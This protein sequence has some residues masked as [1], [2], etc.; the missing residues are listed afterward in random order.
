MKGDPSGIA[1]AKK[2]I[3][4]KETD[5]NILFC[6]YFLSVDYQ[7]LL[8]TC[9]DKLGE[10]NESTLI[11]ITYPKRYILSSTLFEYGILPE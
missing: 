6:S 5:T 9:T 2:S 7:W 1:D 11:R 3:E 8:V 4:I 10:L